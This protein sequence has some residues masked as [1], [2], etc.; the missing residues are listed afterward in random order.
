MAHA[1]AARRNKRI[2]RE[3]EVLESNPDPDARVWIVPKD[4]GDDTK[5]R[6]FLIGPKDTPY[7]DGEFTVDIQIPEDYPFKPPKMK[8]ETYVWH[9]NVSSQT[10][11]ICLDILKDQWSPALTLKTALMSLAALLSAPVPDDPQDAQVA[12]QYKNDYKK[13][14]RKAKMWTQKYAKKEDRSSGLSGGVDV[15]FDL[16]EDEPISD[17]AKRLME[18][19]FSRQQ[20]EAALERT[21]GDVERAA[22]NLLQG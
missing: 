15:D 4:S 18:M 6:G 11:A 2:Q 9:P 13:W 17:E 19:G 1:G 16:S 10:G 5:L 7:E 22:E 8:F 12:S 14:E 21:G 20:S 3:L